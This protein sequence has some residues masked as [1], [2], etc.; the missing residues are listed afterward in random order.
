MED[1]KINIDR[2][3]KDN[4]ELKQRLAKLADLEKEVIELQQAKATLLEQIETLAL[5]KEAAIVAERQARST[6]EDTLYENKT[7]QKTIDDLK[8]EHSMVAGRLKDNVE[9]LQRVSSENVELK[10]AIDELKAARSTSTG[11]SGSS[12]P[13]LEEKMRIQDQKIR[14]LEH[15]VEEWTELAHVSNITH[16]LL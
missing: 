12:N 9:I 6:V 15:N 2:L 8:A 14:E 10:T 11:S 4:C 13:N 7:L 1:L 5:K 16:Y 3:Q